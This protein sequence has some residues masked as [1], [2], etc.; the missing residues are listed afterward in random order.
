MTV[1]WIKVDEDHTLSDGSKVE[2][3]H[4]G[5][6]YFFTRSPLN[7][8]ENLPEHQNFTGKGAK[9]RAMEML[10]EAIKNDVLEK[11]D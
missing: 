1:S 5:R 4:I 7:Y 10:E 3:S 11:E 6:M 8:L 2:V 9:G